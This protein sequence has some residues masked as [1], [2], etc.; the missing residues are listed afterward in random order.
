VTPFDP[1][2]LPGALVRGTRA[3]VGTWRG[4]L[5]LAWI[6]VQ[7]AL[8]VFY[9][10]SRRDPHDERFAWRMFSPMRM[11]QCQPQFLLDD[12]PIDLGGKFHEAWIDIA[13]RG[14][15]D[16]VEAMGARLCHD[17]PNK[18]IELRMQCRQLDGTVENWGGYDVCTVPEL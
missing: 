10:R 17:L 1:A 18:R 14:R 2:E 7:I 3:L 15:F 16:V 6:A 4:R 12:K 11:I 8:P 13:G 5:I 9:Y